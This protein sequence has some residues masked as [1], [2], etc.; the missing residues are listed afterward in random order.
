MIAIDLNN[1]RVLDADP[2]AIHQ[3]NFLENLENYATIFFFIEE[4]KKTKLKFSYRIVKL[5]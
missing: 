2:R 5:L 3:I 4:A 1:Q